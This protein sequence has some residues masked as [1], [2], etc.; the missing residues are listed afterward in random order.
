VLLLVNNNRLRTIFLK[1]SI[2]SNKNKNKNLYGKDARNAMKFID[3]ALFIYDK[4]GD[5]VYLIKIGKID[6]AKE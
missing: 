2:D 3:C 6:G 5:D 1:K 4:N